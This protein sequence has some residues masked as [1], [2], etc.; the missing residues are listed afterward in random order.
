MLDDLAEFKVPAVLFSGGE[1]LVRPDLFEL[2]A[3][4][5]C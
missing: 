5:R 1:P 4:A 3:H 2:A